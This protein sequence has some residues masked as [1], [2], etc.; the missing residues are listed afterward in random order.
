MRRVEPQRATAELEIV[1][2]LA[3][4]YTR[5]QGFGGDG[6]PNSDIRAVILAGTARLHAH[7]EQLRYSE[8]KGPQSVSFSDVI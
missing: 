8:V 5:G 2:A 4:S 6:I 1:T 3:K 7:P